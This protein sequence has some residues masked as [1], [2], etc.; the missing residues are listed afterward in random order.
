MS[1]AA[2]VLHAAAATGRHMFPD[3]V[4]TALRAARRV[5]VLTGAGISAESGIPTFRDALSGLWARFRP[6]DL[7]TPEAFARDPELVWRWY[8]ER[9]QRLRTVE[10]NPGHR[11]L[12]A[13]EGRVPGLTLVTQNVDGLH[14]RA[15]SREVV[16]LHGNITRV[17]CFAEDLPVDQWPDTEAV[18]ACP[19]CG[20]PLRP[21]VVW[22]GEMLPEDALL[23]SRAAARH[24]DVFLS[25]GTSNLVEPAASLPWLAAE[26]GATVLIVNPMADGQRTGPSI[27]PLLGKA[28]VVLP[29]LL[30]EAWPE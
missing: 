6:E 13:L 2:A 3:P 9:R 10:P 21:D 20:G 19:R 29:A 15:G 30:R 17:K 5:A 22:F 28:G 8:R 14:A 25:V 24:C 27:H 26:C 12:V 16:E 23:R 1:P 4:L 11:A 18:P 7:A